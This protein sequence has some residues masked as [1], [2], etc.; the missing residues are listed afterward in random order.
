[1]K[2]NVI[3]TTY[4]HEKYITQCLE[5]ILEQKG[6]YQIEIIVGDDASTDDTR[7]IVEGFQERNPEVIIV[8]PLDENLGVTK[9]LK[10]C[11]D[12]CSG[13][14]IAICEGDDYWTDEY[15]LQK[16]MTFMERHQDFSMCFSALMIYHQDLDKFE[17]FQDQLQLKKNILSTEDLILNNSIGN[18]SCCM[19]RTNVIRQFPDDLFDLFTVDWMFNMVCGQFG[20][21][22]F[23]RDWMSVYRKHARGV[24][25]GRSNLERTTRLLRL[26]DDY[27][28]FFGYKYKDDF[29]ILH[30]ALVDDY[31]R[32]FDY[33]HKD[34]FE[35]LQNALVEIQKPE[36][37]TESEQSSEVEVVGDNLLQHRLDSLQ[38]T[39]TESRRAIHALSM[40]ASEQEKEIQLLLTHLKERENHINAIHQSISWKITQPMRNIKLLVK[41]LLGLLPR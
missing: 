28:R 29:E 10:R 2:I 31:N 35:I 37:L 39:L 41:K 24:W 40:R 25:A 13:E 17:P 12:A 11:L 1:M 36:N 27:N 26:V 22:G 7:R 38:T 14:Y 9:N 21:I 6:D 18:F 8:L 34:D 19:Y 33:K 16:Q 32:F 3:V 4:N 23:I 20:K 5:S 30:N 15:K